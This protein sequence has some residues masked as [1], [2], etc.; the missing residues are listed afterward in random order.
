MNRCYKC[1]DPASSMFC[2]ACLKQMEEEQKSVPKK[3][4]RVD[5]Q[6][7]KVPVQV[8]KDENLPDAPGYCT[9]CDGKTMY[10]GYNQYRCTKCSYLE[11]CC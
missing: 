2:L 4:V 5:G 1:D 7:I 6:R 3:F 8:A 10:W 11:D 9:Q